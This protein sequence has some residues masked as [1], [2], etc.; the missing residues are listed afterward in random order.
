MRVRGPR[1]GKLSAQ[2]PETKTCQVIA[3]ADDAPCNVPA[4]VITNCENPRGEPPMA[5][6]RNQPYTAQNFLVDLGDGDLQGAEAGFTEVSGLESWLDVAE[7][8]AGNDKVA[9]PRKQVG[10][11]RT[12][13]LTLRR[14]LTGSLRLYQWFDHIR[15]GA[16]DTRTVTVTLLDEQRQP[17]QVWK[18][19]NARPVRYAGPVL[20][21]AT[22]DIAIEE[23]VLAYE[24]LESE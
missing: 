22:T 17:V 24:R 21:A 7:Y 9:A 18:L 14:G 19:L 16:I 1:D 3:Q 6:H 23:L 10:L 8:R 4:F 12:G 5:V 2:G 15:N 20:N 11:A 13:N